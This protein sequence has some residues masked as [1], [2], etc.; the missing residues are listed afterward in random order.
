MMNMNAARRMNWLLPFA[1]LFVAAAAPLTQA[2]PDELVRQANAALHAGNVETADSLYAQAEERASDPGL[3][4][5]NRAVILFE[6]GQ[7]RDA[8]RHYDRVLA[9]TA[10]PPARAAKAWYNRGTC[11]LKRGKSLT[12]YRSAVACFEKTLDSPAADEPLKGDARHNLELAKLMWLE[13]AKKEQTP[14]PPSP[15]DTTPPEEKHAPQPGQQPGAPELSHGQESPDGTTPSPS[16]QAVEQPDGSKSASSERTTARNNTNLPVPRDDAAVQS[17]SPDDA[18]A[19]LKET[20]RRRKRELRA[21][22]ET[23]YGPDRPDVRDW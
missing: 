19:Y 6:R 22:L 20:S 12:I 11:L 13:Q 5:F 16:S 18:R 23:L 15:N 3:V 21:L 17:L 10:C 4:A 9:D 1:F 2:S 8:E 14:K 7:Y